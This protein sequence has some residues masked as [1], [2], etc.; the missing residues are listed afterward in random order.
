MFGRPEAICLDNGPD[1]TSE[2][3]VDWAENN[4]IKI[5]FFQPGKPNQNAFI[6]RFNGSFRQE[7]FDA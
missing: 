7:V 1:L 2:T 3:V 6:E 5:L 4:G